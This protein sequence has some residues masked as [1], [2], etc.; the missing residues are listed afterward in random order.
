MIFYTKY[1]EAVA[2]TLLEQNLKELANKLKQYM[3]QTGRITNPKID[4]LIRV[5]VSLDGS[6]RTRGWAV[7]NTVDVWSQQIGKVLDVIIK[8]L[9]CLEYGNITQKKLR[10]NYVCRISELVDR[11]QTGMSYYFHKKIRKLKKPDTGIAS[12]INP[13]QL[14]GNIRKAIELNMLLGSK[15][16]HWFEVC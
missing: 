4:K 5:I 12:L 8:C 1:L 16:K 11:T 6:W 3:Q 13:F 7:N 9:K 14:P 10:S 15:E 2:G